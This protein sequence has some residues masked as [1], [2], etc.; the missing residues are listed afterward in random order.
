[1]IALCNFLCD[2]RSPQIFRS[3]LEIAKRFESFPNKYRNPTGKKVDIPSRHL[4]NLIDRMLY[5]GF[6]KINEDNEYFFVEDNF[7]KFI[8]DGHV[9]SVE[10]WSY[11]DRLVD[12]VE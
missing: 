6:F 4:L 5:S 1:M 9:D 7:N 10:W 8:K 12:Y 3:K 2:E 11:F